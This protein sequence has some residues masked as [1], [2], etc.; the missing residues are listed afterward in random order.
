MWRSDEDSLAFNSHIRIL[1]SNFTFDFEKKKSHH[2]RLW[3]QETDSLSKMRD[4]PIPG[5][6]SV[7]LIML[8]LPFRLCGVYVWKRQCGPFYVLF[9][10]AR[11]SSISFNMYHTFKLLLIIP[12]L[13][14]FAQRWG[15]TFYRSTTFSKVFKKSQKSFPGQFQHMRSILY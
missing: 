13:G 14:F 9:S 15:A 1:T 11:L 8:N 12:L 6:Y 2:L 5:R 4:S 3:C 7:I 10:Q